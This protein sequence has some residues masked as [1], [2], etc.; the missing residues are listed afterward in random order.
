MVCRVRDTKTA[1]PAEQNQGLT[2]P[3]GTDFE[4]NVIP[5]PFGEIKPLTAPP[6]ARQIESIK[7][8]VL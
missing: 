2:V 4:G 3:A 5:K 1:G 8:Y 7:T 6:E